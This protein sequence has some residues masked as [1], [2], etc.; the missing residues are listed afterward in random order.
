MRTQSVVLVQHCG[1]RAGERMSA[2]APGRSF[3]LA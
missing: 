2:D 1:S 3:A